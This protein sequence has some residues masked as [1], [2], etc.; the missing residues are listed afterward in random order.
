MDKIEKII[1]INNS[2]SHRNGILPFVRYGGNGVIEHVNSGNT[3][4]NY[5]HF[6]CDFDI[7]DN[8][9]NKTR[10]KYLD[11]MSRY[12]FIQEC[13]RDAVFVKKW[14]DDIVE[15]C[16]D[17]LS[18]KSRYDFTPVAKVADATTDGSV[19][20]PNFNDIKEINDC[21]ADN[22][23][24]KIFGEKGDGSLFTFCKD[25]EKYFLGIIE[26]ISENKEKLI[27][28]SK[29]PNYVYYTNHAEL[30]GWFD[31]H[32]EEYQKY[33]V[34]TPSDKE[35]II[36]E[37]NERGGD[38]FYEFLSGNTPQWEL[39]LKEDIKY[40]P[41]TIDIE[42]IINAEEEYETLYNVYEYSVSGDTIVDAVKEYV[43]SAS[44][45]SAL[46]P[47]FVEFSASTIMVES[48]LDTLI[49]HNAINAADGIFGI[50]DEFF[51]R[52]GDTY[53]VV[54]QMFKCTYCSGV[55]STNYAIVTY[56]NGKDNVIFSESTPKTEAYQI[57]GDNVIFP[58]KSPETEA[59]QVVGAKRN[60]LSS[61]TE[62][63]T[64]TE[65]DKEWECKSALT[66]FQYEWWEC[67]KVDNSDLVCADGENVTS[68][69]DRYRNVSIVSCID[70]LVEKCDVG[71]TYYV[72]A[73]YDNGNIKP[74]WVW[75]RGEIKTLKIPYK[76]GEP[77]N[78]MSYSAITEDKEIISSITYDI[79]ISSAQ[80]SDNTIVIRYAKGVISGETIEESD[81]LLEESGIHYE[82]VYKYKSGIKTEV[83]IDGV[84]MGE[85][86]YD[87]LEESLNEERVYSEEYR[88]YR[89]AKKAKITGMKVGTMWTENTAIDAML[90]TKEG[91]E[92][93]QEEPKYNIN[94]MYN[95]GNAAAWENHF[96][97]SECNTMEDLENYGNNFFNL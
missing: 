48:K 19:V 66:Q 69:E 97:L 39:K 34:N 95:R 82:E 37:W 71:E 73:R 3:N 67:E 92:G 90:F 33:S 53:D 61:W 64:Y 57:V 5:G 25:V 85:L 51:E 42:T 77:Q 52:N 74:G 45:A 27:T 21:W 84:F 7:L 17:E 36:N 93:L 70:S 41:P 30:I 83:P 29:V 76:I 1:N 38:N 15:M 11:I 86:Y 35:W 46:T 78:I 8:E 18:I 44:T 87:S 12:N 28:G 24:E 16:S 54:G 32:K 20:I 89:T 4:G 59:Y 55:S 62:T 79:I 49:H 23:R 22:Y 50:Y 10:L 2:R 65:N 63:T 47:H 26:V 40:V 14:N 58:E 9:G 31:T 81:M 91:Y 80:T 56:G 96:K 94:L 72:L 60:I 13:F 75:D 6:V 88:Q 43:A 68:G